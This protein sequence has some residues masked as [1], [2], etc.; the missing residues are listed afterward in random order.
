MEHKSAMAGMDDCCADEAPGD[1]DAGRCNEML[2]CLALSAGV[3][4]ATLERQ[5][6]T[7]AFAVWPGTAPFAM[8]AP[9]LHGRSIRPETHP[10][11]ILG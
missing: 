3:N 6:N 9:T 11:A 10:P 2:A 8:T 5:P 4:L 1:H 7:G